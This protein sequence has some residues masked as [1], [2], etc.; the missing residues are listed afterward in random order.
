MAAN[1]T[2][3]NENLMQKFP[4]LS[5]QRGLADDIRA[6]LL[7]T[8]KEFGLKHKRGKS[9]RLESLE[10][11]E[12]RL[13]VAPLRERVKELEDLMTR[14]DHLVSL[15]EKGLGTCF[16]VPTS[17]Q[18]AQTVLELTF[19]RRS[20]SGLEFLLHAEQ[21][22]DALVAL[23]RDEVSIDVVRKLI[24]DPLARSSVSEVADSHGLGVQTI[25]DRRTRLVSK[26]TEISGQRDFV[27]LANHLRTEVCFIRGTKTIAPLNHPLLSTLLLEPEVF[28]SI[29]DVV[30]IAL[31]MVG[32]SEQVN[33]KFRRNVDSATGLDELILE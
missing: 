20:P 16:A 26:L 24:I 3:T 28:P 14:I 10:N 6:D 2:H 31:W 7:L 30:S 11:M 17:L 8:D 5:T 33:A 22:M 21:M 4:L 12:N 32:K 18:H 1:L 23:A 15:N 25:Y 27:I 29:H 9:A 13:Q 19:L